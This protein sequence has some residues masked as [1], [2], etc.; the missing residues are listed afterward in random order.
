[1]NIDILQKENG[2]EHDE[3]PLKDKS[4]MSEPEAP[5]T[6]ARYTNK[7]VIWGRPKGL[8]YGN[9]VGA[10]AEQ[11]AN[12]YPDKSATY[13]VANI[14]L[15]KNSHLII[16]GQY[17]HARYLSLTVSNQLGS[18]QMGNGNF[19]RGDQIIPDPD[20]SNPF[21]ASCGRNV[22][23][24]NFTIY[25]VQGNPPNNPVN[26]TLYSGTYSENDRIHLSVRTYLVDRGYDG[27][28]N[29]LLYDEK[30]DN[31]GL[32]E[33]SLVFEGGEPVTGPKLVKIL[34][35]QKKGDPN[36][37]EL[38]QWLMNVKGS[39]DP[40]NAPCFSDLAS[41]VFWNTDYSVTGAFDASHPE[42]RVV[43][44]PPNNDGGFANNPDTRY[45]VMPYSFGFGE[46]VVVQGKMPTHPKTRNGDANLPEDPQVQYFSISTAAS[47]NC[48]EGWDTVCDEQ[49]PLND[50][51]EYTVIVSWPW[52]RPANA[53]LKN[54]ICW[55][56]P[57][58][59]EG[60]FI[61]A[62]NWVG[63]IYIRYQNSS[64]NW[65]KSPMNIPMP[66]IHNPIPEDPLIMGSYYPF[67]K[68]MSKA[69]FE[70]LPPYHYWKLSKG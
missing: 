22:K 67:G 13:F 46:V 59:G 19:L 20:S 2:N 69:E 1:M 47:P 62:R 50:N 49:I 38:N 66:S 18:G 23:K 33:V 12:L 25:L 52:N 9:L 3:N 60:H 29:V 41:Q 15:P 35:A 34:R 55:L 58:S 10:D 53:T 4:I 21:W 32:P 27:T 70:R 31:S 54:G 36:G 28:G 43:N 57:K 17:P 45:M 48:G 65:K 56:D 30:S 39:K 24:R 42:E 11:K 64:P 40:I 6:N 37:Y 26:N 68:Y 14:C 44:Y 51:G 7:K 16:E 8:I 61:G 63:V 5:I